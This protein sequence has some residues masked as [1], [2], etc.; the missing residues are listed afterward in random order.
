MLTSSYFQPLLVGNTNYER[1]FYE[2]LAKNRGET[3]PSGFRPPKLDGCGSHA[4][5]LAQRKLG[6]HTWRYLYA[7]TFGNST[8][9]GAGHGADIALQFGAIDTPVRKPINDAET[10]LSE[11]LTKA[12]SGF[13]KDPV[14]SL[15]QLGWPMYDDTSK[16]RFV[17]EKMT[18]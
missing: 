17:L 16:F 8:S 11:V 12:W 4:T 18:G 13:A 14:K 1:G 2:Q 5:A 6:G 7:A 15:H 3:L 10:K 9:P